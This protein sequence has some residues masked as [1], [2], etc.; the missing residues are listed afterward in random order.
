MLL[1]FWLIVWIWEWKKPVI[2]K[3]EGALHKK[4]PAEKELVLAGS[5]LKNNQ[6][7]QSSL[8]EKLNMEHPQ[9]SIRTAQ[10]SA[11]TGALRLLD[12]TERQERI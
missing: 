5:V 8:I 7:I 10:H 9:W 1:D 3:I 6:R 4:M 11:A 12:R 2:K